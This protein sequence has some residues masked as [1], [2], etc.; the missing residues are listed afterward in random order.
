MCFPGV[1]QSS[2]FSSHTCALLLLYVTRSF[3]FSRF[4]INEF[5]RRTL[6]RPGGTF[7]QITSVGAR[8]T[9]Q[10]LAYLVKNGY[11]FTASNFP[12]EMARRGFVKIEHPEST[13]DPLPGYLFRDYGFM[14]WVFYLCSSFI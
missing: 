6:L 3:H 11:N 8:G 9:F 2:R 7:D 14:I 5:G 1:I 12:E 13:Q 10:I 4:K